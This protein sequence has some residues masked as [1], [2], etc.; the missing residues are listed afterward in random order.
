MRFVL[1]LMV[2]GFVALLVLP[3]ISPLSNVGEQPNV[4]NADAAEPAIIDS[5]DAIRAAVALAEDVRGMCAR[6]P[7]VCDTGRKIAVAAVERAKEGAGIVASMV[8]HHRAEKLRLT[9]DD[10]APEVTQP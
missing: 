8:E 9:A 10:T 5:S 2:W 7:A 4:A 3:S 1:K 6:D